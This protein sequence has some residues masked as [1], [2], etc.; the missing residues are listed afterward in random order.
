MALDQEPFY[1]ALSPGGGEEVPAR[2]EHLVDDLFAIAAAR[3]AT[4]SAVLKLTADGLTQEE[5]AEELGITLKAVKSAMCNFRKK[6]RKAR[7][8]GKLTVP[9]YWAADR[10]LPGPKPAGD[11][12]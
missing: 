10:T 6:V 2:V 3:S 7:D 9:R 12:R 1:R 4:T 5:I 11:T 8:R